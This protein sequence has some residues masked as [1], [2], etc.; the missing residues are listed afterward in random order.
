MT[1]IERAK[2]FI[3]SKGRV[4]TL[5]LVPLAAL[6]AVTVPAKAGPVTGASAGLVFNST[7][8]NVSFS[9][10]GSGGVCTIDQLSPQSGVTGVTL[11][12]TGLVMDPSG[13]TFIGLAFSG[14]G[15]TNGGSF[16]P[17]NFPVRYDFVVTQTDSDLISWTLNLTFQ[18]SLGTLPEDFNGTTSGG[19]ISGSPTVTIPSNITVS[20]YSFNF[21]VADDSATVG[22]NLTVNIPAG[23]SLDVGGSAISP[24][25][26]TLSLVGSALAGLMWWRRRKKP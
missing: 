22:N 20:S 8:C 19:T 7:S 23:Q 15:G 12:G 5:T 9:G 10:S 3:Q 11:S 16:G 6:T 18:T 4:I 24:E 14:S 13:G 26:A 2:R 1:S 17:G 21:V 25:P